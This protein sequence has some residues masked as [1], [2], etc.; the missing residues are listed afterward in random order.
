M[1]VIL[2]T[3][4]GGVGK[5]SVATATALLAARRGLKTLVMS[6]DPAHSL[7]DC[8]DTPIG[9]EPTMVEG[10]LWGQQIETQQR[11]E[12][13]WREIREYAVE[14]LS[15]LGL[16]GIEAEELSIIPGLDELFS[17]ADLKQHHA[18]GAFDLIVVDC[19][20]TAETLRLLSLPEVLSWYIEK[21]FPIKRKIVK[22]VRPVLQRI[23]SLPPCPTDDVFA[24][25]ERFYD[26]IDGIKQVLVDPDTTS[27]RLVLNPEKMVIA[28]SERTFTYLCLFGYK[29]DAVV[30]NR[31]IPD[32]V[33]DRYFDRWRAIQGE[34]LSRI[35]GSFA[36]VPILKSRLFETEMV[37]TEALARLG[38]EVY[39]DL[40]PARILHTEDVM[41]VVERKFMIK[42][43]F[44]A[45]GD[46]DVNRRGSELFVRVGSSKRVVALPVALQ[47]ARVGGAALEGDW[48]SVSFRSAGEDS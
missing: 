26:R 32:D 11:L 31:I 42:V 10:G 23:Q 2:F 39:G 37:G 4:K 13:G 41:K 45:K 21:V 12:T 7:G 33:T 30:V 48:L 43:P 16:S 34:H 24:A 47:D 15:W 9:D 38:A 3:G 20:P 6:T 40:D 8:M 1:R 19:A 46:I 14:L 28:E 44:A 17:L 27:I 25:I 18:A 29:V 22:T 36:P 35:H 5:T